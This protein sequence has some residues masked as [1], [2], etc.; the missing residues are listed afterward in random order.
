MLPEAAGVRQAPGLE[1]L[2]QRR[3]VVHAPTAPPVTRTH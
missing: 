2:R 1:V 3:P